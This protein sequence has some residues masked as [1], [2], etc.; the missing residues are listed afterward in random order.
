MSNNPF[1]NFNSIP[2]RQSPNQLET[3]YCEV[4]LFQEAKVVTTCLCYYCE[5]CYRD[6]K[7]IINPTNNKCINCGRPIEYTGSVYVTIKESVTY[8]IKKINQERY[9]MVDKIA[10][11]LKVKYII[12]ISLGK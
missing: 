7:S 4:C 5:D 1:M 6:A 11:L 8:F 2:G 12:N 10:H 9:P 3:I